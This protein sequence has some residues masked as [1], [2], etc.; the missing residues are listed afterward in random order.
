MTETRWTVAIDNPASLSNPRNPVKVVTMFTRPKSS[1]RRRRARIIND[2]VRKTRLPA[3]APIET[4]APRTVFRV[5]SLGA[6]SLAQ[7]SAPSPAG[8]T[9]GAVKTNES[10]S[11]D[12]RSLV[13]VPAVRGN[14]G[15]RPEAASARPF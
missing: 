7:T 14:Q 5:R 11:A 12:A 1:L 10:L 2:P 9:P 4:K 6:T 3:C 13:A 8:I 15:R